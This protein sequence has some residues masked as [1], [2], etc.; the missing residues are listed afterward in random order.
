MPSTMRL[1]SKTVLGS[2]QATVTFDNIPQTYTDL[3]V[4]YSARSDRSG[5]V[6]DAVYM[7]LNGST[8]NFSVRF[9][10]GNG[11]SASSSTASV[12]FAGQA[13]A[14]TATANTFGSNQIYI[15]N[16]AGSSNKTFS[17]DGVQETNAAGAITDAIAG[18]WSSTAPIT[19]LGL[20]PSLG[21]NF[22][23]GSTF[24]LYGITG[25]SGSVPG[26]FGVDATGGDVAIS[27]GFKYHVFRSSGVL[28]VAQPG[29]A[30]VLVVGGGGGGGGPHGGGG[31][32]GGLVAASTYVD[33]GSLSVLVGAGG[34][35][36]ADASAPTG[37][38]A[39]G[40]QTSLGSRVAFGGGGGGVYAGS[41]GVAGLPGGSGG[42]G[43]GSETGFSGGVGGAGT[44]GQ[45]FAG[46]TAS[47]GTGGSGGG[48]GGA[49]AVGG[50]APNSTTAGVGGAGSS[51]Y[52]AWASATGTGSSNAYA[53][54]GSGCLINTGS[55]AGGVG[56]GGLG[57]S[58]NP[59][60]GTT[61]GNGVVNTGGGGGGG[62]TGGAG[63]SGIV[64]VRYPVS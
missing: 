34:A 28:T 2:N 47:V 59:S 50:N 17:V 15:P 51:A 6:N 55:T 5:F 9:L 64:I 10:E 63:G 12:G 30:E 23:A 37:L 7:R 60:T 20:Y 8:S 1:I 19:S 54:G 40:T 42:G 57:G 22:L 26:V 43:G 53:G 11:S 13:T 44:S 49:T 25:A 38:G 62:K 4:V 58:R 52:S 16:Y 24:F 31:G 21:S 33:S 36:G 14:A 27:G 3:F 39:S 35:G 45:G 18:L 41:G 48:G 61:G 46:G 56:G 32:A 29:W